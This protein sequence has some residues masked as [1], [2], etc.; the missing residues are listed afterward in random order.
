MYSLVLY[1]YAKNTNGNVCIFVVTCSYH[2][3]C[4]LYTHI[5]N[6]TRAFTIFGSGCTFVCDRMPHVTYSLY[7]R[8]V[9]ACPVYSGYFAVFYGMRI[10]KECGLDD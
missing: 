4:T 10:Y 5:H 7:C 1:A 9:R 3:M 8:N 2:V 6:I